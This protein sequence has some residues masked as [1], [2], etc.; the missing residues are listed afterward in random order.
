MNIPNNS[1]QDP[2]TG[3]FTG[4]SKIEHSCTVCSSVFVAYPSAKQKTCS[5]ECSARSHMKQ[6]SD[7]VGLSS[8]ERQARYRVL[9]RSRIWDTCEC[10]S[11]KMKKASLC[12]A[13]DIVK[14]RTGEKSP[15]WKGGYENHLKHTRARAAKIKLLGDIT[16]RQWAELK[17]KYGNMCLCCKQVEPDIKLTRDHIIPVSRG[18]EHTIDNIQPLCQP[19]NSRKY[20]AFIDF[21]TLTETEI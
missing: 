7:K 8:A 5:R 13:C 18:G 19:C 3:Q 15:Y 4:A 17:A 14:M 11:E 2:N 6:P 10:G 12:K 16:P 1:M 20:N 21:R 9:N